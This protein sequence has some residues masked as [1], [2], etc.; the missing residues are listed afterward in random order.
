VKI[1]IARQSSHQEIVRAIRADPGFVSGYQFAG[2]GTHRLHDVYFDTPG[3][4]LFMAGRYLRLRRDGGRRDLTFR[5]LTFN[6]D[7]G[8][9]AQY[10][11]AA[12]EGES[13]FAARW[14]QIQRRLPPQSVRK[15]ERQPRSLESIERTLSDMGLRPVLEVDVD[16][17]GWSVL[18]GGSRGDLVAR[19]KYDKITYC[20]PGDRHGESQVEFEVADAEDHDAAPRSL[21]VSEYYNFL[22]AFTDQ[23]RESVP[24]NKIGWEINA[25]YFAGLIKLGPHKGMPDWYGTLRTQAASEPM[26]RGPPADGP[27]PYASEDS[28]QLAVPAWTAREPVKAR[29]PERRPPAQA[30]RGAPTATSR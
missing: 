15:A 14:E 27:E 18:K 29:A 20:K 2:D 11:I 21:R 4:E 19:L 10:E 28:G 1:S 26:R 8:Q 13:D 9:A 5:I 16:R 6:P 22:R 17:V 25:K 3:Q 23:C 12:K 24:M 7:I 30:P